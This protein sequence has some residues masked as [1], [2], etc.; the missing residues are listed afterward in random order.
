MSD[1]TEMHQE[2]DKALATAQSDLAT[3]ERRIA[4]DRYKY[5]PGYDRPGY[6]ALLRARIAELELNIAVLEHEHSVRCAA[7]D[8]DS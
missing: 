6:R 3:L 5:G 4:R 8:Q 2:L 1:Y 7:A